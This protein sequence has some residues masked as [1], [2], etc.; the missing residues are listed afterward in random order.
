MYQLLKQQ[1]TDRNSNQ[2]TWS[3]PSRRLYQYLILGQHAYGEQQ[4]QPQQNRKSLAHGSNPAA[5]GAGI[6]CDGLGRGGAFSGLVYCCQLN[7]KRRVFISTLLD[8]RPGWRRSPEKVTHLTMNERAARN[9][10]RRHRM[11][12]PDPGRMCPSPGSRTLPH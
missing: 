6:T 4:C 5:A 12:P 9:H 11:L 7:N 10:S 2:F 1:E 8:S 3:L